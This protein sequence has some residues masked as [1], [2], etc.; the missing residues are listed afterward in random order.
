MILVPGLP[1]NMDNI[2]GGVHS[3]VRNLLTGFSKFDINVRVVSFSH[4]V[5]ESEEIRKVITDKIE[6]YYPYEGP[7]PYHSLNYL[8]RGPKIIKKH[9]KEF[10]PDIIHYQEGSSF[11]FTRIKGLDKK[12]YLQTI[13]GMAFAEAK[14]KKSS[15]DKITWYFNGMLQMSMLPKNVIHL[16]QF[17]VNLF[18]KGKIKYS[19]IIPNAIIPEYFQLTPKLKTTNSLLY[20]GVIDNNKNLMFLLQSMCELVRKGIK[21]ELNVL[22]DYIGIVYKQ[23]IEGYIKKNQLEPYI[24]FNGWVPQSV[25]LKFIQN[26]DIL[27]VSSKHESLPMVI[28][29]SMAAGKVVAASAVG[30]IPEMIDHGI[31]GYLFNLSEKH[32]LVAILENLYNNNEKIKEISRRANFTATRYECSNVAKKTIEFYKR[33]L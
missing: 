17:S 28:A 10:N 9:I 1:L 30:G 21:Y 20:V 32:S 16:S 5:K 7:Y 27:V 19:E 2:K 13:H 26:A 15:K 22:G 31:N 11:M 25:V 29:E 6:I 12:K 18:K 4:E 24:I 33:C 8:F 3:S 23:E 14:R